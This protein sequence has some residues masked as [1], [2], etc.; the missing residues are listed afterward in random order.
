MIVS[1]DRGD[2]RPGLVES[3]G[4]I[5]QV[6]RTDAGVERRDLARRAGISYSYLSA[7]EAGRKHPS[8]QVLRRIA[9]S[10]GLRDHELLAA[11]ERR[12]DRTGD[13]P[14]R[15]VAW[16]EA[17]ATAAALSRRSRP[18]EDPDRRRSL[19]ELAALLPALDGDALELLLQLARKLT[20]GR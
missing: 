19:E 13:S 1:P 2:D 8:A 3:L 15:R 9:A 12:L 5:I 14:A 17:G 7:I 11:A 4:R 18:V 20:T 16:L 6:L 10:L